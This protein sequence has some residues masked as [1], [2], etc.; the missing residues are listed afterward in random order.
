M[1]TWDLFYWTWS[2]PG[3]RARPRRPGPACTLALTVNGFVSATGRK[4][5]CAFS[6][7]CFE[8]PVKPTESTKS[9]TF[10]ADFR[11]QQNPVA[12]DSL[13]ASVHFTWPFNRFL[14]LRSSR[15]HLHICGST[16]LIPTSA[17]SVGASR[18]LWDSLHRQC[19][20][21]SFGVKQ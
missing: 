21:L 10:I 16:T 3:P 5:H 18:I 1:T 19:F 6:S 15:K 2:E 14:F 12:T 17:I 11:E 9:L 4:D 7:V 8:N 13:S 20:L